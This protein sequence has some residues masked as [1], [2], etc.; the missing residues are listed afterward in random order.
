MIVRLLQYG[1]VTIVAGLLTFLGFQA[2]THFTN[3]Q[4]KDSVER[5]VISQLRLDPRQAN[6]SVT[7]AAAAG[8]YFFQASV[9]GETDLSISY[10]WIRPDA[11]ADRTSDQCI[12]V[13]NSP[14]T[15]GTASRPET[16]P[17]DQAPE[18][19]RPPKYGNDAVRDSEASGDAARSSAEEDRESVNSET[20]VP[21]RSKPAGNGRQTEAS[22]T[23]SFRLTIPDA[24]QNPVKGP[25][26]RVTAPNVNLRDG[27][28]TEFEIVDVITPSVR[29]SILDQSDNWSKVVTVDTRIATQGWIWSELIA[30]DNR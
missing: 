13:A 20:S 21:Q 9:P 7:E 23:P 27:P 26:F 30:P 3:A 1:L 17:T 24:K 8:T 16:A 5:L 25:Y 19:N 4:E 11:C 28:G 15:V 10:G 2:R 18:F 29:F 12:E 14:Q 22:E 6:V